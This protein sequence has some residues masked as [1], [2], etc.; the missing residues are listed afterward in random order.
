MAVA[1]DASTAAT[2]TDTSD[3]FTFNHTPVGTPKGVVVA[4]MNYD[5][6]TD[7]VAGVTYGGVA[8]T[9]VPPVARDTAGEPS[10][11]QIWFLG[12]SIPTGTQTVSV[13]MTSATGDDMYMVCATVTAS[14]DTEVIGYGVQEEDSSNPQAT[15]AHGGR[16]A[17]AFAA[18]ASGADAAP[19]PLTGVTNLHSNDSGAERQHFARQTTPGSGNTTIGW[20]LTS[21]DVSFVA[22]SVSEIMDEPIRVSQAL[23]QA[24]I[25]PTTQKLRVT[26]GLAQVAV[27]PTTQK[28]RVTQALVQVLKDNTPNT[29]VSGA[30]F[31]AY[32]ID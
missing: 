7:Q 18:L 13:D 2:R 24:A 15:I 21:D 12:A 4:I 11:T 22:L 27:S 28:L 8:M 1:F 26:Q 5:T 19:T 25:Q 32:V 3:P 20:T 10:N 31:Q 17:I 16:T 30:G 23:V 6:A 14:T 9:R 29:A